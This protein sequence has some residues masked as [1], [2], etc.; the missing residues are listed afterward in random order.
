MPYLK[1]QFGQTFYQLRGSKRSSGLP[2]IC[3]HGGP[4]GHSRFMTDLFRLA[5]N[6]QV[7]IY[8]QIGGGRSSPTGKKL[9]KVQTFVHELE[10]LVEHL[11]FKQFHLFGGSWG[12]TLALEYYLKG[13]NRSKVASLVFQ[14]PMFSATDWQRDANQLVANLP[15]KERKIIRYCHEIEAT[16]SKVYQDAMKLYYSMHVCRNKAK[17]KR[18]ALVKNS[19]GNQ[20]YE[21]MWGASEFSATGTLKNYN[22]VSQLEKIGCPTLFICGEYDEARPN[23]AKQYAKKIST[24]D[25]VEI[26]NASHAILAERPAQLV[27]TIRQFVSGIDKK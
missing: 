19:H 11:G 24:A 26:T 12:T 16:D 20:V 6:R 7:V 1:H 3:L 25:F 2:I 10:L 17:S 5:D 21:Y 8:D 22:K 4:G 13:R 9:W 18:G 14:S 27:K 15:A 23:T